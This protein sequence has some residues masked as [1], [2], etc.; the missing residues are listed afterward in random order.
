MA[1]LYSPGSGITSDEEIL[2]APPSLSEGGSALVVVLLVM[3][4]LTTAGLTLVY[5]SRTEM[6]L[7][8][9]ER[10]VERVFYAADSG[11]SVGIAKVLYLGDHEPTLF[12]TPEKRKSNGQDVVLLDDEVDVSRVTAIQI[13][14][15]D[16]CQV[17]NGEASFWEINHAVSSRATRWGA[18]AFGGDRI[19]MS[20]ARV[21]AMV[22][23]QPWTRSAASLPANDQERSEITF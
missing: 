9:G 14:P 23:I 6:L 21:S 12:T 7:S 8:S 19:P 2:S 17:N 22:E 18:N 5:T 4:V 15:C 16:L 10:T 20:Q 11:I 3:F 1:R 13:T